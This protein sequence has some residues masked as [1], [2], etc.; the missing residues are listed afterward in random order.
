MTC[1]V[2]L[3]TIVLTILGLASG[4][5]PSS[6]S[7][8]RAS[9][10]IDW[11]IPVDQVYDGGPG[12]DGIPALS[13]PKFIRPD[14]ISYLNDDD[15]VLGIAIGGQARAYPHPILDWHE[16]V[17][18]VVGG[19][20]IS[21][22]YCP[23]TGSG[24]AWDRSL[25]GSKTTFGVSG[26]LY[27]SNLVPF[28]RET[29]SHWSQMKLL[30]V[31]GPSIGQS[32]KIYQVLETTWKTWKEL[33]PQTMVLSSNTGYSRPYGTYPYGDYKQSD[34]LIFP[35]SNDDTRLPRKEKV[36]GVI[37]GDKA[38]AYRIGEFPDSVGVRN[39]TLNSIPI[40]VVGSSGRNFAISFESRHADG[41]LLTFAPVQNALPI[42]M[43]DHEGTKWDI[44][45][46][47]VKGPRSGEQL[48][49]TRSFIAYWFAWG[50]F[51]PDV[52]IGQQ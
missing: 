52:E 44:F 48:T 36:L 47:G 31:N 4:C 43:A 21:I 25:G 23:L 45:G 50:A 8:S 12:K 38:K 46:R 24:V 49:A 9:K 28:D 20:T 34:R 26:L 1:R 29:G 35:I 5:R 15:L 39:D 14:Q 11:L 32:A 19:K 6:T 37:A 27:N 40:V 7:D 42:V 2:Y 51:Y 30:C 33:Y 18:D 3:A 22:T 13:D 10:A 41:T 16:I 17:N